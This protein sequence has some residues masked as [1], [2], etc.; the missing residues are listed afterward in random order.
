MDLLNEFVKKAL[1]EDGSFTMKKEA[2][3][4]DSES[5]YSFIQERVGDARFV[6][7]E[8]GYSEDF[9]IST[10]K[11]FELTAIVSKGKVYV[12]DMFILGA[13]G[14]NDLPENV[15][16]FYSSIQK[17]NEKVNAEIFPSFYEALDMVPVESEQDCRKR[18]RNALLSGKRE[19]WTSEPQPELFEKSDFVKIL[20]GLMNAGEEAKLRLEK[21]REE[22]TKRKARKERMET[23]MADPGLCRDWE[24][25]IAKGLRTVNATNVTVIFEMDGKS[26]SAKIAPDKI[27]HNLME[28][29]NFSD[30]SFA[31]RAQGEKLFEALG[32]T[33]RWEGNPLKC[34]HISKIIYGKKTLY[35]RNEE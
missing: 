15:E 9:F 11:K 3:P 31:T 18:A 30:W 6:Y 20:C 8:E 14:K 13:Y 28:C 7:G 16:N 17:L 24:L 33:S 19:F 25:N 34:E 12:L 4:F 29:D 1:T 35:Q 32:A 5:R 23:L 26:A 21:E 22:W 10:S 2:N 27:L